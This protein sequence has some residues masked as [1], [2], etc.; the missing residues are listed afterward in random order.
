MAVTVAGVCN[1]AL[2]LIGQRQFITALNE[3]T[4]QSIN[5]N[6]FFEKT[7]G[8]V[9]ESHE[10]RFATRRA[11]LAELAN[12][13]RTNWDFVYAAPTGMVLPRFII[14]DGL[15]TPAADQR[16]E[17]DFEDGDADT[18]GPVILS[19]QVDAELAYVHDLPIGRFPQLAADAVSWQLAAYLCSCMP[20]KPAVAKALQDEAKMRLAKAIAADLRKE[21]KGQP[22]DA[23]AIRARL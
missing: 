2:G 9:L 11:V 3:N 12:A 23:D 17:F 5:C 20:V 15:R 19:N 16:I 13:E 21:Q 7:R 22:P 10:W 18:T 14:V 1:V 8:E 4:P 6:V